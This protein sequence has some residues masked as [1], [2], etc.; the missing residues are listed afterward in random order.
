MMQGDT[1]NKGGTAY[2]M[3]PFGDEDRRRA[4]FMYPAEHIFLCPSCA[5]INSDNKS[6]CAANLLWLTDE[7]PISYRQSSWSDRFVCMESASGIR[8]RKEPT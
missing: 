8:R 6:R 5:A 2:I 7:Q 4:I 3:T 1:V